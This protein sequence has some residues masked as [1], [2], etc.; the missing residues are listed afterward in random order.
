MPMAPGF[1]KIIC[2]SSV[3]SKSADSGAA[4]SCI[5]AVQLQRRELIQPR[6]SAKRPAKQARSRHH[7]RGGR[8]NL[9]C[10]IAETFSA[11]LFQNGSG[12]GVRTGY[13]MLRNKTAT[14]RRY[15]STVPMLVHAVNGR[16]LFFTCFCCSAIDHRPKSRAQKPSFNGHFRHG[17]LTSD[18]MRGQHFL[19]FIK[20]S[21]IF[22]R[23][24]PNGF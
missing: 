16:I 5:S 23:A 7:R 4:M 20:K 6:R 11:P 22:T 13:F 14:A 2:G 1:H 24:R 8:R 18:D 19:K 10:H 17:V 15:A 12:H 21:A 3:G 9:P